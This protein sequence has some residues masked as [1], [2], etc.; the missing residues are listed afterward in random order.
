MNVGVAYITK[1]PGRMARGFEFSQ[2]SGG[3][4]PLEVL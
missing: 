2:L 1:N 3:A 4:Q